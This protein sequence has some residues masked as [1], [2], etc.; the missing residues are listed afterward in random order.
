MLYKNSSEYN[1]F[2]QSQVTLV[3]IGD[4]EDATGGIWMYYDLS[5]GRLELVVTNNTT[6]INAAGSALQSTLTTMFADDTWQFI[7]LKKDG[8]TFTG[9]VNGIQA[10]TGTVADTALGNK[11]L[12]IGNIPGRTTTI[13][14]FRQNEQL[15]ATI[16]N[17]P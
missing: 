17:L 6:K 9:Y 11:D 4:A 10:F 7:G 13:G 5:S 2:S 14:Q 8:N 16:D 12:H 1:D 3:A 15:Q